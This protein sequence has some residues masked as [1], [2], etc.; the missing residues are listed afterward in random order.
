M[1][2]NDKRICDIING[3]ALEATKDI[4]ARCIGVFKLFERG[5]VRN[6]LDS[7]NSTF[8]TR[9]NAH[10]IPYLRFKYTVAMAK[11]VLEGLECMHQKDI[12]H[13]DIKPE[14]ICVELSPSTN[15]LRFI[16]IDLG[17]AVSTQVHPSESGA[18]STGEDAA[19]AVGFTG[20]YTG[21]A[22]LKL[23]LGTVL[24]M[25]P[26]HID[27]DRTV[28]P[29]TD[30]FSLGVT[31]HVCLSGRYPFVQPVPNKGVLAQKLIKVY[32]SQREADP[33]KIIDSDAQPRS[34]EQL[35]EIV[36]RSLRKKRSKRYLNA[37]AM[38]KHI[39][40]IGRCAVARL[41]LGILYY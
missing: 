8:T 17:A 29:R 5:T 34:V 41:R 35:A 38:K 22:G 32:A 25:S 21:M 20:Q 28:D 31:I 23:P 19:S 13:R 7:G 24:F 26:E 15:Q 12:V 1:F 4:S 39:E 18:E 40:G 2:L 33:L 11:D 6:I 30:I 14:N 37:R 9:A 36:A 10:A 27:N 16:I 3:K